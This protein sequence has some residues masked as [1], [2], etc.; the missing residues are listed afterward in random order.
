[1]WPVAWGPTTQCGD[2]RNLPQETQRSLATQLGKRSVPQRG[3]VWVG[4]NCWKPTLHDNAST[5][6]L[7]RCGTDLFA[8]ASRKTLSKNK[9]LRTWYAVDAKEPQR[10]PEVLPEK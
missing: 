5:H 2:F 7:P 9:I 1:M 4:V 10:K 6:T 3:S 8:T